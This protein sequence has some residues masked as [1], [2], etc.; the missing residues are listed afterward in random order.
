M[1]ERLTANQKRML[2]LIK[3]DFKVDIRCPRRTTGNGRHL[4]TGEYAVLVKGKEE[5]KF[6]IRTYYSLCERGLINC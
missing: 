5:V 4:Y 3:D 1:P 6:N 2:K